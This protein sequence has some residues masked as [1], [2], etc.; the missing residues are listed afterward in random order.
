M[1]SPALLT[2][3]MIFSATTWAAPRCLDLTRPQAEKAVHLMKIALYKGGSLY[4]VSKKEA[5]V[6]KPLGIW[7]EKAKKPKS[8]RLDHRIRA[9]GRELDISLV[10]LTKNA[11]DAKGWNLAWLSGCRPANDKPMTMRVK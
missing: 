9:D 5:G 8:A 6:V 10:Y 7:A 11:T 4:Y 2:L 3:L 1:K